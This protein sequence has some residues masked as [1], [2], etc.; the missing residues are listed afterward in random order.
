M[1]ERVEDRFGVCLERLASGT[2]DGLA[3]ALE[4]F[5]CERNI[6]P[7]ITVFG[8]SVRYDVSDDN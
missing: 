5:A 8:K 3:E 7:H 1:I 6:P 4:W 2:G